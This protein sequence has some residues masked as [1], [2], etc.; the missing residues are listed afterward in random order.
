MKVNLSTM[1]VHLSVMK[2]HLSAV[3][4]HLSLMK[5]HLRSRDRGLFICLDRA[6]DAAVHE[7]RVHDQLSSSCETYIEK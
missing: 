5:V 2:V 1:K 7:V 3:T 4:V 6:C